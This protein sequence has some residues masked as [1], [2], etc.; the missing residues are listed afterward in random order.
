MAKKGFRSHT[1]LQTR[2][3]F[4]IRVKTYVLEIVLFPGG[5]SSKLKQRVMLELVEEKL[6]QNRYCFRARQ[7]E[8]H[9]FGRHSVWNGREKKGKKDVEAP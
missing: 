7:P 1:Q 6:E 4:S 5:R 3:S 2:Y 8:F 9:S